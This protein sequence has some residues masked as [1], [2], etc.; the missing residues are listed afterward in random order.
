MLRRVEGER[1]EGAAARAHSMQAVLHRRYGGP[2]VLTVG[3]AARPVPGD[4]EVLVRVIA[5]GVSIG[6]HHRVAG[7]P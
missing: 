1:I 2:E 3:E 6:D 7:K 4:D 5:A